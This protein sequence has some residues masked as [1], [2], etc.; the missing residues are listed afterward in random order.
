[1]DN[2]WLYIGYFIRAYVNHNFPLYI[3][4]RDSVYTN[5]DVL[6]AGLVTLY[7]ILI[8]SSSARLHGAS[9]V[10]HQHE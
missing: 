8:I 5:D 4:S 3:R 7:M 10:P 9:R 1:M 6:K 2:D